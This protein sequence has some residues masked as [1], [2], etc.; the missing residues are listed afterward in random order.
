[1]TLEVKL[2]GLIARH[3]EL[4]AEMSSE[5]AG[6]AKAFVRLSKEYAELSPVVEAIQAMRKTSAEMADLEAMLAD[7][8]TDAEMRAMASEERE[9]LAATL[10]ALERRLK[11]PDGLGGR[12]FSTLSGRTSSIGWSVSMS[13]ARIFRCSP[14]GIFSI[15]VCPSPR[16]A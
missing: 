5:A 15:G 10:P 12:L 8:E 2:D 3:A 16:S 6:D 14:P 13:A 7:A 11:V 9:V 4:A 1:M